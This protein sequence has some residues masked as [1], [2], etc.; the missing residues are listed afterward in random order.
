MSALKS[1]DTLLFGAILLLLALISTRFPGF[2]APSNLA[3]VLTDT[4][5]LIVLALGQM[6]VILTRCIDLSVAANLALTGMVCAMLNVAMPDLPMPVVILVALVCGAC[7]GAVNGLLVWKLDI[8][9]IVVT[10]GTMTI[11]RGIIFLLSDGQWINAHEMSP[12]FTGL[13]RTVI[14]GLPILGWIAL[15]MVA[16][17]AVVMSRTPLGRA[18]YAVGGNP[19][20][21]VYTGLDVGR[22]QFLAFVISGTLA[23]L[24]G[25]LWIA[26]YAVA[27]VDI[28]GGFE[29]DV[30][31][32]CV[33]GGISIAG[34]VGTVVGTL[35]GAL[36]LGVV[37]NALP[38]VDI[39]PFWQLAISGAAIIIAVTLNARAGRAKGRVILKSAEVTR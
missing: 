19:R 27:Y 28:A 29:L 3:S 22:T 17:M 13:P 34:G 5:P 37:K 20:A 36:F 35:L 38:V 4:S 31:A 8:P 15:L 7:L 26:R 12:A 39:S 2:A 23:G 18:F 14:L 11:F 21:A 6:V 16:V 33:I 1:R 30:V 25:Y 10:L 9:P 32:A 24:T